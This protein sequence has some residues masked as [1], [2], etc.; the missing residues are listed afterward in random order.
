M[1]P[2]PTVIVGTY[3]DAAR[4]AATSNV[5]RGLRIHALPGL[6]DAIG[7][8]CV[9]NMKPSGRLLDLAAGSGAMSA[10]LQDLG[11]SLTAADYVPENFK[12]TDVPFHQLDLNEDFADSFDPSRRFDGIVASEIIEHL[13]NPYHFLRQCSALLEPGGVLVL[14][15]PNTL[16]SASIASFM[17]NGEFLWFSDADRAVQGHITP[18]TQWQLRHAAAAAGLRVEWQGSHGVRHSKSQ[19]SPRLRVLERVFDLLSNAPRALR[20]EIY[21]CVANKS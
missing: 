18:L 6:H 7:A 1:I 2:K 20:G 3:Q 4:T 15:T 9:K 5:Y 16:S 19:G 13:E 12:A 8:L 11:F 17:R 10:R 21:L 14:S